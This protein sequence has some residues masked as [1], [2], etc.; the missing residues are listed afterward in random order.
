MEPL[1]KS[2]VAP[3]PIDRTHGGNSPEGC[4]D[5]STSLNPLGPP[6]EAL[7]AYHEAA[8]FISS[9]PSPYPHRIEKRVATWLDVDSATVIASNGSTQ[10]LYLLARVLRL[11]SP[12]V[13][14][15]T[16][17]EIA[18]SLLAAGATPFP[19]PLRPEKHFRMNLPKLLDA[20][21]AESDAVFLGRPNSPTGTL[22]GL[23]ETAELA[24]ECARL[25]KWCVI[26]EAFIEFADDPRSVCSLV[27][28]IPKLIVLRS[29]TKIFAIPGLRLGYLVAQ[30]EIVRRLREAIDPWSVNAV[31]EHVGLACFEVAESFIDQTRALIVKERNFLTCEL[32]CQVVIKVFDSAANFLM[33]SISHEKYPGEFGRYLLSKGIAIRDLAALPGCGPGQYRIGVRSRLDNTRLIQAA[34]GYRGNRA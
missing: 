12:F 18:N 19:I 31:A 27:Q 20:L 29:L 21:A 23:E 10:L 34:A 17:S 4:I 16:F 14:I 28:S 3:I 26:D 7:R 30:Q 15:P 8:R 33:L 5:F 32:G 13:V 22:L 11:R 1:N 6:N 24:R 9:Y 25:N 2:I